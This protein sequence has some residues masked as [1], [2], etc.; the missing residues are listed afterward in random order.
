MQSQERW[1]QKQEQSSEAIF[2]GLLKNL[3]K[4]MEHVCCFGFLQ[5]FVFI[6]TARSLEGVF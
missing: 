5:G 2:R 1:S 3:G 6:C 4:E